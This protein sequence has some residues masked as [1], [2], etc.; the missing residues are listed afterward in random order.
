M[1]TIEESKKI[2][3]E[4]A[5]QFIVPGTTIGIGTGSTVYYFIHALAD[6]VKAGFSV[7]GVASS[8]GTE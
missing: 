5:L 4:Y 6:K 1:L 8:R 3:G 7:K 2:A